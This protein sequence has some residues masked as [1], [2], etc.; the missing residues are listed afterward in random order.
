MRG[1]LEINATN[2]ETKNNPKNKTE[3]IDTRRE[4]YR[5]YFNHLSLSIRGGNKKE[6]REVHQTGIMIRVNEGREREK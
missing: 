5:E 4:H 1:G 2:T 3:G 6:I